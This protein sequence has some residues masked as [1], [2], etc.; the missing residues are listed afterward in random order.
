MNLFIIISLFFVERFKNLSY[1]PSQPPVNYHLYM[2]S[3]SVGPTPLETFNE[4]LRNTNLEASHSLAM[5]IV[6]GLEGGIDQRSVE[7]D[8]LGFGMLG[9]TPLIIATVAQRHD[10]IKSLLD[11][12][13]N[14]NAQDDTGFTALHGAA[15]IRGDLSLIDLLVGKGA[16]T[17]MA[18]T[19]GS[20]A[21]HF[22]ADIGNISAVKALAEQGANLD[23]ADNY[24]LTALHVAAKCGYPDV[25]QVLSDEGADLDATTTRGLTA[26]NCARKENNTDVVALLAAEGAS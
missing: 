21:L 23:L 14:A 19:E 26:L 13:A 9:A 1:L 4:A 7:G 6:E 25:I 24:G 16:D 3:G 20:T 5:S 8:D 2:S 22:A 10:V 15:L 18:D 11:A 12:G 17:L